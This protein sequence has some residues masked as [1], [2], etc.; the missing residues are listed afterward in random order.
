[1]TPEERAALIARL[2]SNLTRADWGLWSRD[3]DARLAKLPPV[4]QPL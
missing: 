1:L 3:L 4:A 2:D